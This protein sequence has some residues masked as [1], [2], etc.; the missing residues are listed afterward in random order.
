MSMGGCMSGKKAAR[1][2][3]SFVLAI[4]VSAGFSGEREAK[5][6][7]TATG[8]IA[9]LPEYFAG[10]LERLRAEARAEVS[11]AFVGDLMVH[12]WQADDAYVKS[13]GTYDFN[14]CF[15]NVRDYLSEPDYTL[16]NLETTFAGKS[17]GYSYYPTFN[18]PDEFGDALKNA[19]FDFVT[20]A[21]NH[22]NDKR[23]T[24]IERTIDTLDS[25]GL[26]HTG[27][28]K[29]QQERDNV[30]IKEINGIRFAVLSYTYGTNGI[31]FSEPYLVNI[32][33]D[34]LIAADIRR[35]KEQNPDFIIVLPHMG[36]EYETVPR[37]IFKTK[38]RAMLE[39]G[40]DIVLASHPHVLQP[41]EFIDIPEEGGV[42]RGFAAYSLGNFI[43]SQRTTPRDTGMILNFV[44][45]K[46]WGEKAVI[47]RVSYI[48]TWVKFVGAGGGYDIRVL[49]VYD[50][51][52]AHEAGADTG[53]RPGDISRLKQ[54]H[55]E[56]SKTL[57]GRE[58]PLEEIQSE[59]E[60]R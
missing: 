56:V 17:A 40:A 2:V 19:G 24:G 44:F 50:A 48:P 38:I 29:S 43:S 27:T 52:K 49:S 23:K 35:A 58:I 4:A 60:F 21:N 32:T 53:V 16:G 36:N 30:F 7:E 57:L 20:T 6:A 46:E 10:Q 47:K 22:C 28:Y 11:M 55:K 25:L 34:A 9:G 1:K 5:A 54:V 12:E 13:S 37:D 15:E 39:A 33:D 59:Y 42:R 51:L 14:H 18:A 3:V 45:E 31:P 8:Y 41:M 26:A